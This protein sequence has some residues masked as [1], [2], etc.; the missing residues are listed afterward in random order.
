LRDWKDDIVKSQT[1]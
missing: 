1:L